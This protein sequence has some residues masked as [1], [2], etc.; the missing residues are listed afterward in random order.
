MKERIEKDNSNLRRVFLQKREDG[1]DFP[2]KAC[3]GKQKGCNT[4]L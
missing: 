4:R 1:K 3:V 2:F